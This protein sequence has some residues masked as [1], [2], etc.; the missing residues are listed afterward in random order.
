MY[1]TW[2]FQTDERLKTGREET[3]KRFFHSRD[4]IGIFAYAD[5]YPQRLG[6]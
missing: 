2:L 1:A 3:V 5:R 4:S 6:K